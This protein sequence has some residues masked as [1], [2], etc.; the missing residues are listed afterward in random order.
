MKFRLWI[1]CIGMWLRF[2]WD[3]LI[4]SSDNGHHSA[5]L[6]EKHC[7][8]NATGQLVWQLLL[9][10]LVK[11]PSGRWHLFDQAAV[12]TTLCASGPGGVAYAHTFWPASVACGWVHIPVELWPDC[13]PVGVWEMG[14]SLIPLC[15]GTGGMMVWPS[16]GQ[17]ALFQLQRRS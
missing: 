6:V 12:P 11:K 3:T 7:N 2:G 16:L 10:L 8:R 13:C 4:L 15:L 9:N 1:R 5:Y 14:G 17:S